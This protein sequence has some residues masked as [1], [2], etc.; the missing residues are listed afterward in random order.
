MAKF[1]TTGLFQGGLQGAQFGGMLG[2]GPGAALEWVIE[3]G[4][5]HPDTHERSDD[6]AARG[7][8]PQGGDRHVRPIGTSP[9]VRYIDHHAHMV[10][11]T[12]DDYASMALS[13]CIAVTEPAFWAGWDRSTADGVFE[14]MLRLARDFGTAFV[15]VTHDETLAARCQRRFRLV[16]G[17]LSE[18]A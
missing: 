8:G 17:R 14:L 16:S 10:S 15:M 3:Q 11:R 12:T 13:G 9:A 7:L 1:S 18:G 2:G 4:G 6:R 5:R